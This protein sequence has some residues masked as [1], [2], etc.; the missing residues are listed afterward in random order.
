[1]RRVI[2]YIVA[3]S[4]EKILK[5]S[6]D[7]PT[8]YTIG[9]NVNEE[10]LRRFSKATKFNEAVHLF[11]LSISVCTFSKYDIALVPLHLSSIIVQRYNRARIENVLDKR[12]KK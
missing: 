7:I 3:W 6:R 5:S 11:W 9:K 1:M 8:N 10:S 12:Y 4:I 2:M